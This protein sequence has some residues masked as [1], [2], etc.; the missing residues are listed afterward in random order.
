MASALARAAS[1]RA[2]VR[3]LLVRAWLRPRATS[4]EEDDARGKRRRSPSR[5][6]SRTIPTTPTA[7]RELGQRLPLDRRRAEGARELHEGRSSTSRRRSRYYNG[8][9]RSLHPPRLRQGGRAG[10]EGSQDLRRSPDDKSQAKAVFGTHVLLAGVYREK[11]RSPSWWRSWRRRRRSA[12]AE[13]PESVH[14]PVHAREQLREAQ[15][16]PLKQEAIS[17]AQGLHRARLQG[18]RR[19]RGSRSSASRRRRS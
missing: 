7:T 15:A 14:D 2:E 10:A 17:D 8:P 18:R 13:G 4:E 19:R 3:Q 1:A 6:A 11:V 9:R 12:P 5:S 16:A